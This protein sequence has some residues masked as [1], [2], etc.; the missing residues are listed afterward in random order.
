M[1]SNAELRFYF[2]T[3]KKA[4]AAELALK[5]EEEFKRRSNSKVIKKGKEIIITVDSEDVVSLR[6]NINAYLRDLQ[7]MEGIKENTYSE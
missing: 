6:A 4:E 7:V 5:Q 1:K 2:D 3:E